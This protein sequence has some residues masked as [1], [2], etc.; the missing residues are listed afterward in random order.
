VGDRRE[1]AQHHTGG[2]GHCRERDRRHAE[3]E[4]GL[5]FPG[6]PVTDSPTFGIVRRPNATAVGL[7][8]AS[9]LHEGLETARGSGIAVVPSALER[10]L[11]T[12]KVSASDEDDSEA[13]RRR[14]VSDRLG[15]GKGPFCAGKIPAVLEDR[16]KIECAVCVATLVRA[17]VARRGRT[18]VSALF[19]KHAEVERRARMAE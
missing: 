13:A 5:P 14:R 6:S 15:E 8:R 4:C 1:C 11:G 12:V 18:D 19:E 3:D 9:G 16:A 10:R 17:L 7:R 2:E